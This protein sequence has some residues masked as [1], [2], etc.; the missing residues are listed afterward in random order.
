MT[1]RKP[2]SSTLDPISEEE[3]RELFAI[4]Q[5]PPAGSAIE[6]AKDFGVDL[7]ATLENLRL[8]PAE[9]IRRGAQESLFAERLRL[10]GR[11]AGL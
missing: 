9:R 1:L 5:A 8:T 2:S 11:K 10:A 3:Y 7:L 4:I 6:A